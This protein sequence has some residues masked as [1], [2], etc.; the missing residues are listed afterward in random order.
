MTA[1]WKRIA[2]D[3]S[4]TVKEAME[5]LNRECMQIAL[6]VED[7]SHLKGTVTDGDIRRAILKG[8]GL[9][10]ELGSVMNSNPTTGL[11]EESKEI[12]Q[13][14]M[15]RYGLRHL[16]LLDS[17][18]KIVDLIRYELPV[19]P[20]RKNA[21]VLMVGGLGSRL[22][23][24]T[25]DTPKPLIKVGSK[26][27]LETIIEE[28]AEQGFKDIYLCI[29]YMGDRIRQHFGD[30]SHWGVQIT[31]LE[32]TKSLGTAGA[33]SLFEKDVKE[34]IIVMNGDLLT[35]VDFVRLA[36]FH[37]RHNF[38]ATMAVRE[39]SHQVPYGVL[40]LGEDYTLEAL[41]E[42]PVKRYHVNAGIYIL[43]PELLNIVPKNE[44][45]DMPSLFE[46]VLNQQKPVGCYPIT[47]YWIDIGRIEDLERAHD[48][49]SLLFE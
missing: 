26:P 41:V 1:D 30:G 39:Y 25:N 17:T 46:E 40:E 21:V 19:E 2:L 13:R 32:E 4:S 22:R 28:F 36:E 6:V 3:T 24:L 8:N 34:P 23:P 33:L 11:V 48:D 14:T 9:D 38:T 47:D 43:N 27:V 29:R 20:D 18:G 7:G 37:Q 5:V 31:Y 49:Y 44:Y 10:V 12:W 16:P 45:Y 42:K 15:Q 35:K